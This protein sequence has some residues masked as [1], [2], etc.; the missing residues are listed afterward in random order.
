MINFIQ[1]F[2]EIF[3]KRETV[4]SAHGMKSYEKLLFMSKLYDFR[5]KKHAVLERYFSLSDLKIFIIAESPFNLY[6]Y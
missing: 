2:R 4:P 6:S 1:K 3:Q 5:G